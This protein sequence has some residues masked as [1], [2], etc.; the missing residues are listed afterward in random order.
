MTEDIREPEDFE[1]LDAA[2]TSAE[3]LALNELFSAT[4]EELRRL[5]WSVKRSDPSSTLSPTALVNEAWIKL[6]KSPN[7]SAESPLHFKR[8]AARAMRRLRVEAA[9]GRNAGKR[10]GGILVTLPSLGELD[11]ETTCSDAEQL[12]TLDSALGELARMSPRQA[13]VIELRFFGGLDV[14]ETA[15]ALGVSEPT[16]L[17]DWRAARAWLGHELRGAH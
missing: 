16:V 9:G 4:Y 13:T 2:A 17:R 1:Y 12:L 14:A 10:G 11:P 7:F 5:A 15:T 3:K 6:A 8:L